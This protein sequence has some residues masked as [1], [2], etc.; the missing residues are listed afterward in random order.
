MFEL[1]LPAWFKS[2]LPVSGE[3]EVSAIGSAVAVAESPD[4]ERATESAESKTR[5]TREQ[6]L[7]RRYSFAADVWSLGC[8]YAEFLRGRILSQTNG[9]ADVSLLTTNVGF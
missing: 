8:I 3:P 6:E 4:V 1:V 9:S 2:D 7:M 5:T